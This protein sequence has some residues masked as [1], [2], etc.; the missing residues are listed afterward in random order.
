MVSFGFLVDNK[1]CIGCHACS[2]ACKSE[3]EVPLGVHRTW[4]KSVETGIYP[5]VSRSFQV[6]R[7]N[8]CAN[9]PCVKICPVTAMYQREDGIVEFD[10]EACIGCKACIQACPYDAIYI[11]PISQ[12]AAKCHYCAHRTEI[13]LEPACVVV[14]PQHAIVSGDLDDPG[15]EISR[16][17]AK[18]KITV[19]KPEQGTKPKL[20]YV[21]GHAAALD[22]L[23]APEDPGRFMFTD[24]MATSRHPMSSSEP[25]SARLAGQMVQVGHNNQHPLYWGWQVPAYIITKDI[26]AGIMMMLVAYWGWLGRM[27]TPP[28]GLLLVFSMIGFTGLTAVLLISDLKRPER[29]MRI[30]LRPQWRSWLTRGAYILAGFGLAIAVL[31]AA[32]M[33]PGGV[34]PGTWTLILIVVA[35]IAAATAAYTAYLLGQAEGRDLWQSPLLPIQFL[36]R[37]MLSGAAWIVILGLSFPLDLGFLAFAESCCLVLIAVDLGLILF[38]E[39]AIPHASATCLSAAK[40]ITE[41]HYRRPYWFGGILLGHIIPGVFLVISL[42]MLS[43]LAAVLILIGLYILEHVFI[44]A[45]QRVP[46]S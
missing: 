32:F 27:V 41:G 17:V 14:C 15:S 35:P 44:M 10:S 43:A 19:R 22:P 37:S 38:A 21:D 5:N 23:A 33:V 25:G 24:E 16:L 13:G 4:V 29:F 20:F 28:S 2:T 9:P 8:H 18:E 39:H 26:A 30:L 36:N 11:D 40:M 34:A 42:P 1:K 46:N 7:C 45:P 3:N 6:T 12:T 31:A